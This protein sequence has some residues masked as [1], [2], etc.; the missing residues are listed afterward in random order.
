MNTSRFQ[1]LTALALSAALFASSVA[2]GITEPAMPDD[3][4]I[5]RTAEELRS[6][7]PPRLMV[8]RDHRSNAR[9][10]SWV[11][12][13]PDGVVG[14]FECAD[15]DMDSVHFPVYRSDVLKIAMIMVDL[16]LKFILDSLDEGF[17]EQVE[18]RMLQAHDFEPCELVF[19][20]DGQVYEGA[21][22]WERGEMDD[23]IDDAED[24]AFWLPQLTTKELMSRPEL[25]AALGFVV[26]GGLIVAPFT[27]LGLILCPK[28]EGVECPQDPL[29]P[30]EPSV[31]PGPGAPGGDR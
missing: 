27:P 22:S 1:R 13:A 18:E 29:H 25:I 4:D 28:M 19:Y 14:F 11:D 23:F 7:P 5:Q 31:T 24:S 30:S 21:L 17:R 8:V 9:I 6:L 10:K 2:C 15:R 16:P 12:D 26:V 3:D 20:T